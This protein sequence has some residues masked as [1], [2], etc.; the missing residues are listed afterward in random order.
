PREVAVAAV[1]LVPE[2]CVLRAP[3]DLLRL[4]DVRPPEAE[5]ERLEAHRLHRHVA[6]EDEEIRPRDLLPVLL[7]DRPEQAARLVQVRVVGPAVERREPL[8]TVP[9]AAA[10]VGDPVRAG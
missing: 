6:G 4:P 7:L 9:G 8:L 5:A 10:A 2:P 3:E 1:S